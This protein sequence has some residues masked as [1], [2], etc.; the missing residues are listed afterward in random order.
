ME[1]STLPSGT[2]ETRTCWFYEPAEKLRAALQSHL[3]PSLEHVSSPGSG[4]Q[5]LPPSTNERLTR[6]VNTQC[7][8]GFDPCTSVRTNDHTGGSEGLVLDTDCPIITRTSWNDRIVRNDDQDV[9][10][11]SSPKT[12]SSTILRG[13]YFAHTCRILSG[14]DSPTNPLREWVSTLSTQNAVV[15]FCV[16]SISAAHL[17]Q[18]QKYPELSM[19]A[20]SHHTDV[21]S[22]LAAAV[23][24]LDARSLSLEPES[25][26]RSPQSSAAALLLGIIMFGMTSSW[27]DPSSLGS[28]HLQAARAIFQGLYSERVGARSSF[29]PALTSFVV[30]QRDLCPAAYL[31]PL[32]TPNEPWGLINP[33]SGLSTRLFIHLSEVGAIA[34]QL[35]HL[36]WKISSSSSS[37]TRAAS[38]TALS[39][40]DARQPLLSQARHLETL[41]T[42]YRLPASESVPE[43]GDPSA[44]VPHFRI[45]ARV[46]QLAALLE[47]Y[48]MFPEL[49]VRRQRPSLSGRERVPELD[50]IDSESHSSQLNSL[51]ITIL[52]LIASI[53]ET[54]GTRATQMLAL[55]IAGSTL[56]RPRTGDDGGTVSAGGHRVFAFAPTPAAEIEHWRSFVASRLQNLVCYVGLHAVQQAGLIVRES[57]IR[58]DQAVPVC[59]R[60]LPIVHWIDV[61]AERG[62]ETILG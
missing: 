49:L 9:H 61:M 62:L 32:C 19:L 38:K 16:L 30:D 47:L 31:L 55:V 27:H 24:N 29:L 18:Q 23:A 28:Q 25:V 14:F 37:P 21:L 40:P 7:S 3:Q 4:K 43:T 34:R 13:Y 45:L 57:W 33:W 35:H 11:V 12:D 10:L 15:H 26:V 1:R 22:S 44:P 48:R 20:L 41:F 51:A 17:S 54:S 53:P 6:P 36:R 39:L 8:R 52:A 2:V 58:A 59:G 5:S 50:D 42:E 56:R 46:Y 60:G